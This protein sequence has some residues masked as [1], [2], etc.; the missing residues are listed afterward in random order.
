MISFSSDK[1]L[2]G[3]HGF[4]V[5]QHMLMP[6]QTQGKGGIFYW[7][8]SLELRSH[9]TLS[10]VSY[11]WVCQLPITPCR[12]R[13]VKP[14]VIL[15]IPLWGTFLVINTLRPRQNGRHFAEDIFKRIFM[16]KNVRISINISLKFVP[17]GLINNIPALVQI[18]AWCRPGDKPLSEPM[19]VNLLTHICVTRPQWVK[20]MALLIRHRETFPEHKHFL[21]VILVI[22]QH[23][24]LINNTLFIPGIINAFINSLVQIMAWHLVA[25]KPLS[26]PVVECCRYDPQELT[27]VK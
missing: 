18:M 7:H 22:C 27:S 11:E 13:K 23:Q 8:S 10:I 6:N 17:K 4:D 3:W 19:M 16:N 26:E 24:Y 21:R 1:N 5:W 2:R 12:P 15:K 9:F 20:I 25:A 14:L